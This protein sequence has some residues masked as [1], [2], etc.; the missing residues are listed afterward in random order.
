MKKNKFNIIR[1][2]NSPNKAKTLQGY[3]V[4]RQEKLFIDEPGWNVFVAC[5]PYDN[6][7][8]YEDPM[9]SMGKKG[10]G[11]SKFLC[12]CGAVGVVVGYSAYKQD[13]SNSGA[14]LVCL[15]HASNGVHATG[16]NKWN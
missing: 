11:H 6:H 3:E 15:H 9:Y 2:R 5:A 8:I 14:M 7:F 13:A 4:E 12:T 10:K 16:E 1:Y